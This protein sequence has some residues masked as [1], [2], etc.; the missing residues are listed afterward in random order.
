MLWNAVGIYS[1]EVRRCRKWVSFYQELCR[2]TNNASAAVEALRR[3]EGDLA[4]AEE[5]LAKAETDY[6]Q[7]IQAKWGLT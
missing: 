2:V 6:M 7:Y 3:A 4:K 5:N 1:Y